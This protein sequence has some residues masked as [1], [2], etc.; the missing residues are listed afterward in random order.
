MKVSVHDE[1]NSI[2]KFPRYY[3]SFSRFPSNN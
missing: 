1:Q 3:I 2:R